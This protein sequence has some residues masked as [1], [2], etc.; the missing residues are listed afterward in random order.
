[1]KTPSIQKIPNFKQTP[2]IQGKKELA[3]KFEAQKKQ[4]NAA[5]K[6]ASDLFEEYFVHKL[7]KE[8]RTTLPENTLRPKGHAEKIFQDMLDEKYSSL[9]TKSGGFGMSKYIYNQLKK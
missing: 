4:F 6:D 1:M 8:M 2:Q 9:I 5:L 7:I 3:D